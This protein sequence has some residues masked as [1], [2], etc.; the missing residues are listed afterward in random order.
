MV[1]DLGFSLIIM[2]EDGQWQ[3]NSLDF[4]WIAH[5]HVKPCGF[6]TTKRAQERCVSNR[7]SSYGS[8]YWHWHTSPC[9]EREDYTPGRQ[10]RP[11]PSNGKERWRRPRKKARWSS[12]SPPAPS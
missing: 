8:L 1:T 12:L 5:L 6:L 7:T 11:R 4:L 9:S 2:R 10:N 3:L